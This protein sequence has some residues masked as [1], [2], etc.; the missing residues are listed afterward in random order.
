MSWYDKLLEVAKDVA[1]TVAGG[2]AT[3]L[4]GGNVAL[5]TVVSS[6]VG[7]VV[8]DQGLDLEEASELILGDPSKT[9]EFRARMREAEIREL[10][11]R[12][13]D[14]S[15]ARGLLQFSKGPV[16]VST[17]VSVAFVA[18]TGVVTFVP[19]PEASQAVAYILMGAL[20]TAFTQVLNFWLG[21]SVGS[22]EKDATIGRFTAAAQEAQRGHRPTFMNE[23]QTNGN[24]PQ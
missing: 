4:S 12:Q 13:K 15:S 10:E 14:V 8:G 19:I 17:L 21:T 16:I 23:V 2:A 20:A 24:R 6:I 7:K 22:K 18:L 11:V 9:M 5:G 3:G 1:P